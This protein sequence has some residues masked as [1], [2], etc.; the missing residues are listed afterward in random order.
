M[1]PHEEP[2]TKKACAQLEERCKPAWGDK[3][4]HELQSGEAHYVHFYELPAVKSD[5]LLELTRK[6]A[7]EHDTDSKVRRHPY[8]HG[9]IAVFHPK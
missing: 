7:E 3:R 1:A 9:M 8:L 4:T 5:E 2:L 6:I